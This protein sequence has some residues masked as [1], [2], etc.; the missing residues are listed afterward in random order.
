MA[1]L[2]ADSSRMRQLSDEV[3]KRKESS[4][5]RQ[6]GR[7]HAVAPLGRQL[8][9]EQRAWATWQ[10]LFLRITAPT[11]SMNVVCRSVGRL[12]PPVCVA[13]VGHDIRVSIALSRRDD[14]RITP[15]RHRI[16]HTSS[17]LCI[18]S[19]NSRNHKECA[20]LP[21]CEGYIFFGR[22][23]WLYI[24]TPDCSLFSP[25]PTVHLLCISHTTDCD[26]LSVADHLSHSRRSPSTMQRIAL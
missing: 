23:L 25:S 14:S 17:A 19:P 16:Q 22:G 21:A 26:S 1:K 18:P 8:L 20:R 10:V 3:V 4:M 9:P 5:K 6:N 15:Y 24:L 12:F 13:S 7:W 2:R 11:P